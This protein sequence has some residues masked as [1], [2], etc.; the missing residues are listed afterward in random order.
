VPT[1]TEFRTRWLD[2]AQRHELLEQ[3]AAQNLL[4]EILRDAA[5]M[6]AYDEFDV[7]AALAYRVPP[8]TREQRAAR[9]GDTGPDWLVK[10]PPLPA[11]V[12]R[13]I[14]RQFERAGTGALEAKELW[15][16]PEIRELKGLDTLKQG[17]TPGE[18]LRKTKETLFAA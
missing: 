9:F 8:L 5:K 11:K 13:A 18:L 14:V 2:P 7:L 17:G 16:T 1:L 15:Q 4:P 10:M 6:D 12:I 3:L